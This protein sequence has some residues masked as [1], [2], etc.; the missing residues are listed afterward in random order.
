MVMLMVA[1]VALVLSGLLWQRLEHIQQEL[2]K[3]STEVADQSSEAQGAA[4]RAETLTQELQARLSVAEVKL[5]EVTLQRSQLE[6]LMLSVSR[7]RDDTLVQDIESGLRLAMQQAELS[8]STQPLIAAL[9]S[10]EKR[11]S[12]SAQPRLNP[13]QRAM[14]RDLDRIQAASVADLP[15]LAYRLDELIR[16]VDELPLR[17][18]PPKTR[19]S[20]AKPPV[21]KAG[22]A[23]GAN[24]NAAASTSGAV[25]SRTRDGQEAA[26]PSDAVVA[27]PAGTAVAKAG[28][29][30]AGATSARPHADG[31]SE[32]EADP[33]KPVDAEGVNAQAP[34][35]AS[36]SKKQVK[37]KTPALKQADASETDWLQRFWP[38]WR[39]TVNGW[40][41]RA[42]DPLRDLVRVSRIED[43]DAVLLT[44]DQLTYL[45]EN[46]KLKLLNA[47]LG[48]LSRQVTA[49][50]VDLAN[51]RATLLKYFD[52][53]AAVTKQAAQTLSD[54]LQST[55]SVVL[56]RPDETLTALATAANGR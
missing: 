4:E 3:R 7:S 47:R 1:L 19:S 49:A 55:R 40:I 52:P 28:V 22:G 8:G 23:E 30:D 53:Q 9:Q 31:P 12:R 18:A 54:V 15:A 35:A 29:A 24:A 56:P 33:V 38:G 6:E 16:W 37:S 46:L 43:P 39:G 11:I 17:N 13:L 14:A 45:R 26:P 50:R 5:S 20:G 34:P 2:A 25:T 48:L 27:D 21:G 32:P 10:A 51:A 36:A 41:T 42:V 44:P